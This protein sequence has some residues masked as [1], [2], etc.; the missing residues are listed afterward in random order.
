MARLLEV[1]GQWH[2]A[3]LADHRKSGYTP[4]EFD[5]REEKQAHVGQL[6]VRL[7]TGSSGAWMLELPT[8]DI[9][10]TKGYGKI[11]KKKCA[12]NINDPDFNGSVLLRD[13]FRYGRFDNR[14]KP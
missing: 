3:H 2:D 8:G 5:S 4:T 6:Y 12:G 14:R 9:Y 10:R 1:L 13:R 7:D 11:D